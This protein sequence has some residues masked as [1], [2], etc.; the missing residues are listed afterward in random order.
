MARIDPPETQKEQV[1]QLWDTVIGTNGEGIAEVTKQ[2]REDIQKIKQAL[3]G[4]LTRDQYDEFSKHSGRMSLG[5]IG[6]A[7]TLLVGLP[8]WIALILS[9][10]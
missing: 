4:L 5:I 10:G 7:I 3:P 1:R 8:S 2:N 6:L 9:L